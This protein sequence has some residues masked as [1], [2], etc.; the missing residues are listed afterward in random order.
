MI[1]NILNAAKTGNVLISYV[2]LNSGRIIRDVFTLKG[3][4]VHQNPG[5]DKIVMLKVSTNT[6]ED[7]EKN[8]IESWINLA[9]TGPQLNGE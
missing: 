1:E 2:S 9:N 7:I 8:T 4:N 5:N 6:Y 3:V